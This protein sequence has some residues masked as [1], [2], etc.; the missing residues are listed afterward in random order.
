MNVLINM[1]KYRAGLLLM[2]AVA[3]VGFILVIELIGSVTSSGP[4]DLMAPSSSGNGS[5]GLPGVGR[6]FS[7]ALAAAAVIAAVVALVVYR[8]RMSREG[9]SWSRRTLLIVAG[10]AL[11]LVAAAVSI[12]FSGVLHF[13]GDTGP[14]EVQGSYIAPENVV[15]LAVF[16]LT[17]TCVAIVRPQLLLLLFAAWLLVGLPTG[18]FQLPGCQPGEFSGGG[19][20]GGGGGLERG[21]YGIPLAGV[22]LLLLCASLFVVTV[23]SYLK[24]SLGANG[25]PAAPMEYRRNRPWLWVL[26]GL[27]GLVA[28]LSLCASPGLSGLGLVHGPDD[29]EDSADVSGAFASEVEKYRSQIEYELP[30]ENGNSAHING[31]SLT[32]DVGADATAIKIGSSRT[33]FTVTGAAHTIYLRNATGDVYQNGSWTQLDTVSLPTVPSD[34]IPGEI[35]AMVSEG[36]VYQGAE[37]AGRAIVLQPH[38]TVPELLYQSA[39]NRVPA[40]IDTISIAP[41]QGVETFQGGALPLSSTP[42]DIGVAGAWN[43]F[44]RTFEIDDPVESYSW[45]S[46]SV[47]FT[48]D[49]LAS[50]MP[51]S[52][53]T[54]YE[55]PDGLPERVY[56]TASEITNGLRSPYQKARA[57]ESFLAAGYS[58]LELELDEEPPHPPPGQDPI[59]WFL[60]DQRT[61]G[62]TAFSSAF[63]VLA[64]SA[65]VPSRVVSG[66]RIKPLQGRQAVNGTHARQ[67][68]EIALAGIGWVAFDPT[69]QTGA[70]LALDAPRVPGATGGFSP[71]PQGGSPSVGSP[72]EPEQGQSSQPKPPGLSLHD[73]LQS[74]D[75]EVRANAALALSGLLDESVL[76]AL[77]EAALSDPNGL[78]RE[79]AIRAVAT[80]DPGTLAEILA[81]HEDLVMRVAAAK[82]LGVKDDPSALGPLTRAL[83]ADLEPEVRSAAADALGSLGDERALLPLAGA[84]LND[85]DSEAAVRAAAALALGDLGQP[86]AIS[87][88]AGALESDG[89]AAVR[90]AAAAGLGE[91]GNDAATED[92]IDSL[93]GDEESGVRAAAASALSAIGD[94]QA[95][96]P[97][98]QARA[99]DESAAVRSEAAAALDEF[100]GDQL[101]ETLE[102]SSI[103]EERLAAAELL[104]ARGDPSAAPGLIGAL[105]DPEI[106]VREAAQDSI[107]QLGVV[108][109]LENGSALLNHS[110]GVSFIPGATTQQAS[111]LNHVP[112]F[113][114]SGEL[115]DGFLRTAI[116]DRYVNGQWLP[117]EQQSVP[118]SATSVISEPGAMG[119]S[120]ESTE[121]NRVSVK[122]AGGDGWIPEGVVPTSLRLE[123]ITANGVYYPD[124]AIFASDRQLSSYDWVSQVAVYSESQ[125]DR[126]EVSSS[127]PYATLPE[128]VP[129]RVRK[130]AVRITSGRQTPYQKARAIEQY[131]KTNYTY[132]LADPLTG[133]VPPGRDPVDWFLFKIQEGTCGNFSSAFVVMARALGIPARVV[134]GW[135]VLPGSAVAATSYEQTVYSDQAH[136]RAEVA[137]EG[138]GWIP[139][140][141]TASQ[142]APGRA[143]AYAAGGGAQAQAEKEAIEALVE[144]LSSSDPVVREEAQE[145]LEAKGATVTGTENGGAVVTKDGQA[146]GIGVGMTTRQVYGNPDVTAGPV[147]IVTGAAHTRYLRSAVGDVYEDGQWRALDPVSIDYDPDESIPQLVNDEING[148]SESFSKLPEDRIN[149][150][151]LGG[152]GVDASVTY[153]D[154]I[155]LE[156]TDELGNIPAGTVPTSRW[157]TE[158]GVPGQVRPFS[159]TFAAAEA[160]KSYEWVSQVPQFAEAQLM[161][162][163]AVDDPTYI[164]L[165]EGMPARI[166]DLALEVTR[167][168]T[169]TYAKARALERY[170]STQY[171]YSYADAPGGGTPPPGQDPV[172]WFLFD[173]REGTCGGFSS[174]FVVMARSIGI[175][176]RVVAGW[177]IRATDKAQ[178]VRSNQAHQWA[179]VAL[180]GVGWVQL[181]PTAPL[182]PQSR[183]Q[184]AAL[185]ELETT[186]RPSETGRD[187][188]ATTIDIT[189]WPER[190]ERRTDLVVGGV[191]RTTAGDQ[192]SGMVVEIFINETKE[193]GGTKIG[194]TTV[195]RGNYSTT[196]RVPSSLPRGDYQLIAHAIGNGPY[197]ES[198]SDPD[199][200]VY[201]ESGLQLTGPGEVAVDV[202]AVFTGRFIDD[203]GGG[204][205]DLPVQVSVD[206]QA[207]PVQ[208]TGPS[209]EFSFTHIFSETGLHEVE[210]EFEG[211]DLLLG[212][213]VRLEVTGVMPTVLAISPI[214][215]V[216]VGRSFPVEG[217]LLNARGEPLDGA[218]V[219]VV[220][221]GGSPRETSTDGSGKFSTSAAIDEFGEFNVVVEF[222]GEHPV[223]PSRA[224]AFGIA[225]DLTALSISGPGV[226][227][228]GQ[229]AT[230][231]GSITSESLTQIGARRVVLVDGDGNDLGTTITGTDGTFRYQTA[232]LTTTGARSIAAR[233]EEHDHLTSSAGSFSFIVVAPTALTVNGPDLA[234]PGETVE[235]TGILQGGAG[236]PVPRAPIWVG[237]ARSPAVVTGEDGRFQ[238]A[239]LVEADLGDVDAESII[240]VPFGFDGTDHLAPSIGKHAITVGIP[241]LVVE[242]PEPAVR[243]KTAT[244]RG[245]VFV[246]NRPLP[247]AVVIME[248]DTQAVSSET[249]AFVLSHPLTEDAP[250]GSNALAV[251]VPALGLEF[252]V[253]IPVKTATNLLVVPLEEVRPGEQAQ[254]R[255]TLSD[256][257]GAGIAGARLTTNQ[258]VQGTTSGSG[259]ALI[260]ITV[261]EDRDLLAVPVTFS[262]AGDDFHLALSYIVAI[263]IT[264]SGFNWL[265]WAGIPALLVAV[266]ASGFSAR[267]WTNLTLPAGIGS[268]FLSSR[269]LSRWNREG[270]G[271]SS[272]PSPGSG[273]P[274]GVG[275]PVAEDRNPAL[276][277]IAFDK[278]APDLPDVWGE[279]EEFTARIMLYGETGQVISHAPVEVVD[280][281]GV[282][283]T[284]RT[285]DQG[286]SSFLVSTGPLGEFNISSRFA[287]NELFAEIDSTRD[288]RVVD[289]SEEI[290]RLYNSFEE[291]ADGQIP[292][293]PGSTPRELE[294][295]LVG[296]GLTF[297]YRAVDEIISR[298]EEADYSEH[299]I[300]RRQYEAMYRSW[301]R[302]VG[303]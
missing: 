266:I 253:S 180:E 4:D 299:T 96:A 16:F 24:K 151:L 284:M 8:N 129:E 184:P 124:S 47:D 49:Q 40:E 51:A 1:L 220:V 59:D 242:R 11:L 249:G 114:V 235:L 65:G 298:F 64:R 85:P 243:G 276:M 152:S 226:V 144:K 231:H 209:G 118:Y 215:Q 132:R 61:G 256:D 230:L 290:V 287:G 112:V 167:G 222:E 109:S 271:A 160:A 100:T 192:V 301:F 179:E 91:L 275:S 273:V 219:T 121:L 157:L 71:G 72:G 210:V 5:I 110:A 14:Y 268:W 50:A 252:E 258:G 52:D 232:P 155:R 62:S 153:A 272:Q 225:R 177:A 46:I 38:R 78:V 202:P 279:D 55:L 77:A 211:A 57:I 236:Q 302:I 7:Y 18:F 35:S 143:P 218:G 159:G 119:I 102:E 134:S 286:G 135:S 29:V 81:D 113:E 80:A 39:P 22:I 186:P 274:S 68:A 260:P 30:M 187:H 82:G 227:P 248:P 208:L 178:E 295:L 108:T 43:P 88:L 293:A 26:A 48:E 257:S 234:G 169:S 107:G 148:R 87:P 170:L 117:E 189:V 217:T 54:Y 150:T 224:F 60:F 56:T 139:F 300:G 263:P 3:T 201:S 6:V 67:W 216:N 147:F 221:E 213:S 264:S 31:Q 23:I 292:D 123:S 255:A 207:L 241:R 203:T 204:A 195:Q 99:E 233:F 33:L 19:G 138:L 245:A 165:P 76:A 205:A 34:D 194:E 267:R 259:I 146:F 261:P 70:P 156:A 175:P 265:L 238:W 66:W 89:D 294:S 75:P 193:H 126:A 63:V 90:E 21:Y 101:A 281:E 190:M 206:G 162:A 197:G 229:T 92:L 181:E 131:L 171:T 127:Y 291:W 136:Q 283:A 282:R 27:L 106:E 94:P 74:P 137:F 104:G 25:R 20:G 176:A 12:G 262:Y 149:T 247:G 58:Y 115:H 125:L 105:T 98:M 9:A 10:V 28:F 183:V 36:M 172:D 239:L 13:G 196:I 297:D 289:F 191:V 214:S 140:E 145:Q 244:V 269:F 296:S 86:A 173:Y 185:T 200:T 37:G 237:D 32:V 188:V 277:D 15:L 166:R 116:G 168:H 84:L 79:S 270:A 303:E 95:L 285:D 246:G 240:S 111:E 42:L 141:P 161:S 45:R 254:V 142:G 250:L 174:G 120:P 133:D 228:Q 199:V 83:L 288:F 17:V 182:G 103:P 198:W 212:N 158:V 251:V 41:G 164:Q 73:L 2:L 128:G 278:P 223:L 154:S 280:S 97:L 93:S 44:S 130:L 53:P 122:P 163:S 69:P